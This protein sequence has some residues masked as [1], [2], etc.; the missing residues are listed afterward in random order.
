MWNL[1][2]VQ[3]NRSFVIIGSVYLVDVTALHCQ[4]STEFWRFFLFFFTPIDHVLFCPRLPFSTRTTGICRI[5]L[6][7]LFYHDPLCERYE[8]EVPFIERVRTRKLRQGI[9]KNKK[10]ELESLSLTYSSSFAVLLVF[11]CVKFVPNPV[12]LPGV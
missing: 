4:L 12:E 11:T 9:I 8:S 1:G 3:V 10:T 7:Q 5:A 6:S 2:H